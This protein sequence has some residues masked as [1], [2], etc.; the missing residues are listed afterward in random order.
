MMESSLLYSYHVD[1]DDPYRTFADS[2]EQ[3]AVAEDL[4]YD[5]VMNSEHHFVAGTMPA[6]LVTLSAIAIKTERLRIGS[7]VILL[8]LYDPVHVAEHGAVIDHISRGRFTLGVGYGYRQE[9]FD[10]FGIELDE[11]P[12]RMREGIEAIRALWTQPAATYEGEHYRFRDVT[13]WPLPLQKPHPPI[14]MASK[15]PGAVAAAARLGDAWFADPVTPFS[16]LKAR[17]EV[18]KKTLAKHG[19]PTVDFDFPL[20]REAYCAETDAQA[21][22][23][24]GDAVLAPY[25]EYLA[26][27]HLLDD[28]G[29]PVPPDHPGALDTV[30]SR[31]IIGSPETCIQEALRCR[32]ELGCTNLVMRMKFPGIPSDGVMRSVRLW[33]EKVIPAIS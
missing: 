26:W 22:E 3:I 13:L 16:V 5:T 28:S 7:G 32:D 29:R 27:G 21:W 33:G 30:R 25:K 8:P 1:N 19:K 4:G 23:E 6:P 17:L 20:M 24:A 31:F 14:W 15:A 9:E 18:Y 10:G 11:R 12:A 2:L